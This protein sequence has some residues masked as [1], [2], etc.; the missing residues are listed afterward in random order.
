MKTLSNN[1]RKSLR[2]GAMVIA[3]LI[4]VSVIG[5]EIDYYTVSGVLKDSKTK[6]RIVFGNV[7][8]PGSNIGTVANSDGEF[9]LKI[10]KSLNV[11]EFEVSH[12]GYHNKR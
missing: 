4:S 11:K 10:P 1:L 12:L 5:Q 7:S 2:Y 6:E 9:T 3:F 8:V